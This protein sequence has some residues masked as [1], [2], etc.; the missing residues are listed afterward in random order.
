VIDITAEDD[1]DDPDD[2]SDL[3]NNLL[4]AVTSGLPLSSIEFEIDP[5]IDIYSM[6][7]HDMIP[8]DH[9]VNENILS[10]IPKAS[11]GPAVDEE[12]DQN[13]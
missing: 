7:L 9:I 2:E 5:N 10:C 12:P 8:T 3:D 6:A 1:I 11:K 13:F 4:V